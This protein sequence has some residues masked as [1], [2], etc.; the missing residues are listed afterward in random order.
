LKFF[1]AVIAKI[2]VLSAVT[3]FSQVHY[4]P[5]WCS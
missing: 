4:V 5:I 3:P 1:S 2:A